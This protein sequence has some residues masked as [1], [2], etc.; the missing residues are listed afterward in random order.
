MNPETLPSFNILATGKD[1]V[2]IATVSDKDW[3]EFVNTIISNSEPGAKEWYTMNISR[4]LYNATGRGYFPKG[5]TINKMITVQDSAKTNL[6]LLAHEYGHALGL[7]HTTS[8]ELDIMNPVDWMRHTDREDL[9]GRFK[10]NF[11][12]YSKTFISTSQNPTPIGLLLV[13]LGWL[14]L[15]A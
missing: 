3:S 9:T 15:T 2:Q 1:G 11:P 8:I 5:V 13:A 14:Y 10:E 7:N 6:T 12:D 4:T